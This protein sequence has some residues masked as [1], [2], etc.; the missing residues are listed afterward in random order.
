MRAAVSLL[1]SIVVLAAAAAVARADATFVMRTTSHDQSKMPDTDVMVWLTEKAAAFS[2]TAGAACST[3]V[4]YRADTK[5]LQVVDH[6]ERMFVAL[7]AEAI[8]GIAELAS[9]AGAEA[10]AA[11]KEQM[12]SVP[13]EYRAQME[14]AMKSMEQLTGGGKSAPTVYAVTKAG[15]TKTID[16]RACVLWR[17]TADGAPAGDAWLT[18]LE[19]VGVAEKD[20]AS[21]KAM[22]A[23]LND[24]LSALGTAGISIPATHVG[25]VGKLA[26]FP[27]AMTQVDGGKLVSETKLVS[28]HSE[29]IAPAAFEVPKGYREESLGGGS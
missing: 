8:A 24:I 11:M 1:A 13:P 9:G 27:V 29:K 10:L 6:R 23:Q 20:F 15:D 26:A 28:I 21:L 2:T 14:Q 17:L 4:I 16:G 5:G 19:H 25:H 22:Y 12:E 7:D 18:D 3:T